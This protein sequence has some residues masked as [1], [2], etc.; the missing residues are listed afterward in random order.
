[1][2]LAEPNLNIQPREDPRSMTKIQST[3]NNIYHQTLSPNLDQFISKAALLLYHKTIKDMTGKYTE[4]RTMNAEP[5]SYDNFLA[6]Y[7]IL[8]RINGIPKWEP[9]TYSEFNY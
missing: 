7:S 1:M 2:S 3:E 6:R 4:V 5:V 8:E 9:N